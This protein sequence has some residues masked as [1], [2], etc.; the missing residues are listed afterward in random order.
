VLAEVFVAGAAG[1]FTFCFWF[2]CCWWV[3]NMLQNRE[4]NNKKDNT[5][6]SSSVKHKIKLGHNESQEKI[7]KQPRNLQ[8][9]R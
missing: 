9:Q 6:D 8:D 7:Y 1:V 2:A 5:N 4:E 3:L